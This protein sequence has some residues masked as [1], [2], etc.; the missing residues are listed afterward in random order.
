MFDFG[1]L[2][3]NGAELR[4]CATPPG[5][6]PTCSSTSEGGQKLGSGASIT[7]QPCRPP[8]PDLEGADTSLASAVMSAFDAARVPRR[9][10]RCGEKWKTSSLRLQ[11]GRRAR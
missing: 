7:Q 8:S 10:E 2:C 9:G 5:A 3:T 6:P 11:P 4:A 1:S